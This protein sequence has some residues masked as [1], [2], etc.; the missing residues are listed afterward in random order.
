MALRGAEAVEED[1]DEFNFHRK[2]GPGYMTSPGYMY[3]LSNPLFTR[4]KIGWTRRAGA[5]DRVKE[6]NSSLPCNVPYKIEHCTD[7]VTPKAAQW[8]ADVFKVLKDCRITPEG[9]GGTEFFKCTVD[10]AK[11]AIHSVWVAHTAEAGVGG[12]DGTVMPREPTAV[13]AVG[14]AAGSASVSGGDTIGVPHKPA[15]GGV[16]PRRKRTAVSAGLTDGAAAKSAKSVR[17]VDTPQ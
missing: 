11:A 3:V 5:F 6:M 2:K 4:V 12:G 10:E 1:D 14:G 7:T 9:A 17:K 16:G 15:A 8:E 13:A